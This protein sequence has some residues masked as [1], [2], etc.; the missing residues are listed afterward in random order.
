[1]WGCLGYDLGLWPRLVVFHR[2]TDDGFE[3]ATCD[4]TGDDIAVASY[5]YPTKQLRDAATDSPF[6][7][8]SAMRICAS[9]A[10]R[11]QTTFPLACE[12]LTQRVGSE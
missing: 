2:A 12:V 1:M 10:S 7:T 9:P 8:G 4:S 6:S 3:L 11:E 5:R